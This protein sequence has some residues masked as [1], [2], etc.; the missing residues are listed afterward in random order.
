MIKLSLLPAA[1]ASP[2]RIGELSTCAYT[3]DGAQILSGGWD[4]KLRVWDAET[5]LE[6]EALEAG[7]AEKSAEFADHGNAVY[8]PVVS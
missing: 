4:G 7:M 5:G 1:P 3:P 8:L 2:G 6:T